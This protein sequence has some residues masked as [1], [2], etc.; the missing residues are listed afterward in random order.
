MNNLNSNNSIITY[1]FTSIK[2][3]VR[4]GWIPSSGRNFSGRICVH[5]RGGGAKRNF[6]NIDFFR[7][8]NCYGSILK[9]IKLRFYS[10]FVGLISYENGLSSHILLSHGPRYNTEDL[11]RL[12]SGTFVKKVPLKIGTSLPIH[13]LKLFTTVNNPEL[14]PYSGSS[15]VRAAVQVL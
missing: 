4:V 9:Q 3:K 12:Y 11:I 14:Y 6:Y 5:H 10:S 13:Y 7:R 15:L 2:K 8:I 1:V